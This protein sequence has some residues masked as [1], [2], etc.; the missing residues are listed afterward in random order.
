[1]FEFIKIKIFI[2]KY[3]GYMLVEFFWKGLCI[4]MYWVDVEFFYLERSVV[5]LIY[6][7]IIKYWSYCWGG[8]MFSIIWCML[9][10]EVLGNLICIVYGGEREF[11]R[12]WL[13]IDVLV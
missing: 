13:I 10:V 8:I 2:Y 3:C 1:M 9:I 5:D 6:L 12:F 4:D 11:F 7:E